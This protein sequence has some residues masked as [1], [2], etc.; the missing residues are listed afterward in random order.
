MIATDD[1]TLLAYLDG[2]LEH[3]DAEA[4][5]KELDR[6]PLA[7]QRL[8]SFA[9]S[10]ALLRAALAPA[11]HGRMP[12]LPEPRFD[13]RIAAIASWR[14]FAPLA[15]AAASIL[16]L[17][18]VGIGFGIGDRVARQHFE[19]ANALHARDGALAEAA[20]SR[21]LESQASGTPVRWE[22]PDSGATG[23]IK[24]VRTFKNRDDQ[25]CREYERVH[26]SSAGRSETVIGIAC[27]DESGA[28]QTRAVFYDK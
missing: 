18:G 12:A 26:V 23:S 2:E 14:R 21:A 22:N 4:L 1:A 5:E 6:D 16:L 19:L 20:L 3:A 24:P 17:L 10:T 9:G 27:R 7:A 8:A 25:F 28:W 15:A 13:P 11:T